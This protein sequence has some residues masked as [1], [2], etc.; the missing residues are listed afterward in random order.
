MLETAG[1]SI[2]GLQVGRQVER[3][4]ED[5]SNAFVAVL[6]AGRVAHAAAGEN[7]PGL[8]AGRC[9][10]FGVRLQRRQDA[11]PRIDHVGPAGRQFEAVHDQ[12]V[13]CVLSKLLIQIPKRRAPDFPFVVRSV[14]S[15]VAEIFIGE[16]IA[17]V[18]L[19]ANAALGVSREKGALHR[20]VRIAA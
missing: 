16:G 4:G 17:F 14:E 7:P 8:L 3:G 10:V 6:P 20:I 13:R 19:P 1:A 15:V 9:V 18:A 12:P 5:R 2:A 11:V